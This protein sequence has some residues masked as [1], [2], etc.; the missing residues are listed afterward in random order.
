MNHQ[1]ESEDLVKP[2]QM[3]GGKGI[4]TMINRMNWIWVYLALV[5]LSAIVVAQT[6]NTFPSSG[7]VGIGTAS[8]QAKL[9]VIG[10][11]I[12]IN[13]GDPD[14]ENNHIYWASHGLVM[15]TEPGDYAYNLL[16]LQPGARLK[17]LLLRR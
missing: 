8:P 2:Y 16:T 15:G 4:R 6:T 10:G 7:N 13:S 5:N 17:D 9:D 1:V 3:I 11:D 12:H 14:P